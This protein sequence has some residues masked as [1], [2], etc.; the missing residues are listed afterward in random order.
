MNTFIIIFCILGFIIS[1]INSFMNKNLKIV[2]NVLLGVVS[3]VEPSVKKEARGDTTY[4]LY[5]IEVNNV[6]YKIKSYTDL[7]HIIK[8]GSKAR[9]LTTQSG[10]LFINLNNDEKSFYVYNYKELDEK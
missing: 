5:F 6:V 4:Y 9:L 1:S 7:T 3:N 2:K 8:I 10:R